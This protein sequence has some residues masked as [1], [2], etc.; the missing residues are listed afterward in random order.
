MTQRLDRFLFRAAN[1]LSGQ[2][3]PYLAPQLE[4]GPAISEAIQHDFYSLD[5]RNIQLSQRCRALT[6]VEGE[7]IGFSLDGV[8]LESDHR[9]LVG[10]QKHCKVGPYIKIEEDADSGL[11]VLGFVNEVRYIPR[12]DLTQESVHYELRTVMDAPVMGI[13]PLSKDCTYPDK[14]YA[15][16]ANE[17]LKIPEETIGTYDFDPIISLATRIKRQRVS[18]KLNAVEKAL[19]VF[20]SAAKDPVLNPQIAKSMV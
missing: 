19:D 9:R 5:Q 16:D 10:I 17:I 6:Q 14:P 18:Y 12:R 7:V 4:P 1:R 20:E 11:A 8:H 15:R 3:E 13:R 2:E